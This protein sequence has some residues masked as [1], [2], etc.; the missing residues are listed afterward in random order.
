MEGSV[1]ISQGDVVVVGE[2]EVR[3]VN[4]VRCAI[5]IQ[6]L[7]GNWPQCHEMDG[8]GDD[9]RCLKGAVS[10]AQKDCQLRV[11]RV[12]RIQF[13][14]QKIGMAIIVHIGKE[15]LRRISRQRI[16]GSLGEGAIAIS[17]LNGEGCGLQDSHIGAPIVIEVTGHQ[18]VG[19]GSDRQAGGLGRF[20]ALRGDA[21][22]ER[23]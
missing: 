6:I 1:P 5:A 2:S 9:R 16:R 14:D 4:N 12:L 17:Q 8:H 13:Q 3:A 7:Y 15:Q 23:G 10:S 11:G 21:G 19:G 22:A 18:R 20:P